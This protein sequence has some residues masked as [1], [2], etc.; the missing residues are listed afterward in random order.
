MTDEHPPRLVYDDQCGFCTWATEFALRRGPPRLRDLD[1]HAEQAVDLSGAV[2]ERP[3]GLRPLQELYGFEFGRRNIK[4]M[5]SGLTYQAL[6][7]DQVDVALGFATDGRIAAFDFVVLEDD[8][9]YFPNYAL[10]PTVRQEILDENPELRDLLN[11]L[12][13][14]LDDETMASLNASIDVEKETVEAVAQRFLEDQGL[15]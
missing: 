14:K 9:N 13:G 10:T 15:I 3:D 2:P 1:H 11:G 7:Q 6:E 12:S 5:D 8:K 4:K